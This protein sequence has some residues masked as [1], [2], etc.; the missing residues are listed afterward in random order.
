M[1]HASFLDPCTN[2]VGYSLLMIAPSFYLLSAALFAGL[3][4]VILMWDRRTTGIDV[5]TAID[6]TS[7]GAEQLCSKNK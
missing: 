1:N 7:S 4:V 6:V 5:T 3:G 2:G